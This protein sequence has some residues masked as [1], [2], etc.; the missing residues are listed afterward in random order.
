MDLLHIV[1]T[2]NNKKHTLIRKKKKFQEQ[3]GEVGL[4]WG[5]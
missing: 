1:L 5:K 4:L 2:K 3:K